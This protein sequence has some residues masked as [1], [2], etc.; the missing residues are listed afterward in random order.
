[1]NPFEEDAREEV[2]ARFRRRIEH[3][4]SRPAAG[5]LIRRMAEVSDRRWRQY[6]NADRRTRKITERLRNRFYSRGRLPG[7]RMDR[8]AIEAHIPAPGQGDCWLDVPEDERTPLCV[9]WLYALA[10][11]VPARLRAPLNDLTIGEMP[12]REFIA[13]FGASWWGT[14]EPEEALRKAEMIFEVVFEMLTARAPKAPRRKGRRTGPRTKA[15]EVR[16][17]LGGSEPWTGT[18]VELAAKVGYTSPTSLYHIKGFELLWEHNERR[19]T[20]ERASRHGLVKDE[21]P[22]AE[23][24]STRRAQSR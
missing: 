21:Y 10:G 1:M 13:W 9:L 11:R 4:L 14:Q 18:K 15:D 20:K 23:G 19:L 12:A 6:L 2:E 16:K 24:M 7:E 17:L 3:L 8:V 22:A 5:P